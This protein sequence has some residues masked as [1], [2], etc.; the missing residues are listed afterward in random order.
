MPE[1]RAVASMRLYVVSDGCRCQQPALT[2][3]PAQ[4]LYLEL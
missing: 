1:S 2:A 3:E 4:R